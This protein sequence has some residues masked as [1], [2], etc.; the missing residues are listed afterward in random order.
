M[1]HL[2]APDLDIPHLDIHCRT[3][4]DPFLIQSQV[5]R[6][7]AALFTDGDVFELRALAT[8]SRSRWSSSGAGCGPRSPF[9]RS[10]GTTGRISPVPMSF[11]PAWTSFSTA[12]T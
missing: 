8:T 11:K 7:L 10:G 5:E 12:A 1:S 9:A 2:H 6:H 3:A 4:S